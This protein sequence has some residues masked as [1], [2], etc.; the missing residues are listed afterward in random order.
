M[1]QVKQ[2]REEER[3]QQAKNGRKEPKHFLKMLENKQED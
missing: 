3:K 1:R 2:D